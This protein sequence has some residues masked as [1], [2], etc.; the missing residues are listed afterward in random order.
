MSTAVSNT[1]EPI[2]NVNP[3]AVRLIDRDEWCRGL[4]LSLYLKKHNCPDSTW[5]T[6]HEIERHAI[7]HEAHKLR[8]LADLVDSADSSKKL[9][10]GLTPAELRG[11]ES[12]VRSGFWKVFTREEVADLFDYIAD[13]K[14]NDPGSY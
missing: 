12:L 6:L 14:E 11:I 5:D 7:E 3:T 4:A 9:A 1:G 8:L 2:A 10:Q 13:L